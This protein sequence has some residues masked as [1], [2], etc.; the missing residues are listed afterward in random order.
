M[1]THLGLLL[2][3]LTLASAS[4]P[5]YGDPSLLKRYGT[6]D[7][8]IIRNGLTPFWAEIMI[9]VVICLAVVLLIVSIF[10]VAL[11]TVKSLQ[12]QNSAL[13]SFA[14]PGFDTVWEKNIQAELG[15]TQ[16]WSKSS[17]RAEA[18]SPIE[19]ITVYPENNY[20]GDKLSTQNIPHFAPMPLQASNINEI[21]S[22]MNK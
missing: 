19:V 12:D 7:E 15:L 18:N 2:I 11:I 1:L 10:A 17:L 13:V 4:T 5:Q 22:R 9:P 21:P 8:E 20:F 16:N 14:P 6:V 3:S